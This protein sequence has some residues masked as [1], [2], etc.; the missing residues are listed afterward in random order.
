MET[1]WV[2]VSGSWYYLNA[3]GEMVTGWAYV[4]N[5]WYYMYLSGVMATNTVINGWKIDSSGVAR[6]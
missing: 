6:Q 5:N 1:G 2:S 4:N 3:Y